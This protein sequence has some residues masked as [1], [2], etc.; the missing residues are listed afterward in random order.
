MG[1]VISEEKEKKRTER[2]QSRGVE[3]QTTLV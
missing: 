3:T 2:K 1:N